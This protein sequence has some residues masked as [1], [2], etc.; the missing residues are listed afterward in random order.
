MRTEMSNMYTVVG[1]WQS[2]PRQDY[3][4]LVTVSDRQRRC[5][6]GEVSAALENEYADGKRRMMCKPR[7][8]CPQIV[9]PFELRNA[10]FCHF[11]YLENSPRTRDCEL[12]SSPTHNKPRICDRPC[13]LLSIFRE[14]DSFTMTSIRLTVR[15]VQEPGKPCGEEDLPSKLVG[16]GER[17]WHLRDLVIYRGGLGGNFWL[18]CS[19]F[20][21]LVACE[22]ACHDQESIHSVCLRRMPTSRPINNRIPQSFDH[23]TRLHTISLRFN[24]GISTK[25]SLGERKCSWRT[26][27]VASPKAVAVEPPHV[28]LQLSVRRT[29]A[30]QRPSRRRSS[31]AGA[32][33]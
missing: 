12:A 9:T 19:T 6:G 14:V 33:D 30:L 17:L 15:H 32:I 29:F 25:T 28:T 16:A 1:Y 26:L 4:S 24:I 18:V 2:R 11:W 8:L 13:G 7:S 21:V 3:P 20:D 27:A 22:V 31:N 5:S 10:G 23:L